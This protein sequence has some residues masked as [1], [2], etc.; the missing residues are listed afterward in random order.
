MQCNCRVKK[1]MQI[2]QSIVEKCL[3]CGI[4]FHK[5]SWSCSYITDHSNSSEVEGVGV[6]WGL[7]SELKR[8]VIKMNITGRKLNCESSSMENNKSETTNLKEK[9]RL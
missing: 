4:E 7:I 2:Y 9:Q 6:G 5:S 1:W 8:Q 3:V